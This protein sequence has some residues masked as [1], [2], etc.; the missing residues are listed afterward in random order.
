M[1]NQDL[2]ESNS[3]STE[4]YF[5][6]FKKFNKFF[7]DHAQLLK[8]HETI[9]LQL[10]NFRYPTVVDPDRSFVKFVIDHIS[11]LIP[12]ITILDVTK[13][14]FVNYPPNYT[15]EAHKHHHGRHFTA[16][17]YLTDIET[18]HIDQK[19]GG[20]LWTFHIEKNEIIHQLYSYGA[21]KVVF[22]GGNVWHGTYPTHSVR[23]VFVCDF[24]YTINGV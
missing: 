17:L 20:A 14:W 16:V 24:E 4:T 6:D 22:L 13:S 5:D 3:W 11:E 9:N 7:N 15:N 8:P 21:G 18:K 12:S 1:I 19:N 2:L 10:D 23:K